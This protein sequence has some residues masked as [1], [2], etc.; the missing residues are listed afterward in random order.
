MSTKSD[1]RGWPAGDSGIIVQV[2]RQFAV[3]PERVNDAKDAKAKCWMI[4]SC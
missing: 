4:P 1:R 2:Q 3:K